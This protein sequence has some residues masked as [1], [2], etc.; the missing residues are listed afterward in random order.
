MANTTKFS[1]HHYL[2]DI[3]LPNGNRVN[4]IPELKGANVKEKLA[5]I[6]G[7]HTTRIT[8]LQHKVE[9]LNR[10]T[11]NYTAKQSLIKDLQ[12]QIR[13]LN[14]DITELTADKLALSTELTKLQ[15]YRYN[16]WIGVL[17]RL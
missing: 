4:D 2:N 13:T 12:I 14:D 11:S 10:K 16:T 1:I 7:N 5:T 9:Q 6:I 3:M 15:K 17:F 8:E